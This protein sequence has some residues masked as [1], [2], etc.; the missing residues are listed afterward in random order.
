VPRLQS[1]LFALSGLK[2]LFQTQTNAQFHAFAAL[3]VSLLG[4]YVKISSS[5]WCIVLGCFAWII[6]LEA[7]NTAIES[8]CDTV[9]PDKHPG[10][11][12]T[13]DVAAGA[14]LFSAIIVS[15][16]GAIIFLPKI[17]NIL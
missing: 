16:I 7:I 14:V 4:F 6:S 9:H 3:I 1:F 2:Y 5:E 17:S 11:K 15:I 12:T 10:I 8:L 13:K